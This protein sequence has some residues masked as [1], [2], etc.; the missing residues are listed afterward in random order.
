MKEKKEYLIFPYLKHLTMNQWIFPSTMSSSFSFHQESHDIIHMQLWKTCKIG[1]FTSSAN[2]GPSK[3]KTTEMYSVPKKFSKWINKYIP[4]YPKLWQSMSF[5]R[6]MWH[7]QSL[8]TTHHV[9]DLLAY[10]LYFHFSTIHTFPQP[11]AC[12][13]LSFYQWQNNISSLNNTD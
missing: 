12:S 2:K 13:Q 9:P 3:R 5:A 4:F 11:C 7:F 10:R 1:I 8:C 6:L